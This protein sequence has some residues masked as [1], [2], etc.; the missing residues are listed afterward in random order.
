VAYVQQLNETSFLAQSC[1]MIPLE[2]VVRRL[3][4]GS[5]LKRNQVYKTADGQPPYRFEKLY[6]ELF[7]K[8]TGGR[9]ERKGQII[10]D[11]LQKG[12]D[13]PLIDFPISD[14][15]HL[16]HSKKPKTDP[17]AYLKRIVST[18][19][20]IA[21]PLN[22]SAVQTVIYIMNLAKKTFL[23]LEKSWELQG[24][25]LADFKL[26]FGYSS[27][28]A[29]RVADVIDNDS[30][31]LLDQRGVDR[32]KQAFRDG[33]PLEQVEANY[34]TIAG[35]TEKFEEH[36]IVATSYMTKQFEIDSAN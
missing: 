6:C 11:G 25:S 24:F 23:L 10:V 7:L 4:L 27:D 18:K 8:T 13:D 5:Y 21:P 19:S 26:E 9:L 33:Q 14:S 12:E 17:G 28:G 3:A 32:S 16:C 31:R 2:V 34:A 30:W 36:Q 22:Q 35:L 1:D 15:W 20:V 29:L